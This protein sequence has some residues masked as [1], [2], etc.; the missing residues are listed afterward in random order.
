MKLS[1]NDLKEGMVVKLTVH[2][3]AIYIIKVYKDREYDESN[4]R[5]KIIKSIKPK[6]KKGE[7]VYMKSLPFSMDDEFE[8]LT[9]KE[10]DDLMVELL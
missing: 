5:F 1:I 2:K 10:R 9:E 7:K 8:T 6:L 3:Q 4:L